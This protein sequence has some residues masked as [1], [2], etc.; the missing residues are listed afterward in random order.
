MTGLISLSAEVIAR[1]AIDE[2]AMEL[3][4]SNEMYSDMRLKLRQHFDV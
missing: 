2:I 3:S 4:N 1:H